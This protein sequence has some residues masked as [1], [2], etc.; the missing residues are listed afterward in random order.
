VVAVKRNYLLFCGAALL[1]LLIGEG[2]TIVPPDATDV[3]I[4]PLSPA[5][6][7][8][9]Y[10]LPANQTQSDLQRYLADH[11]WMRDTSAERSL[12]RDATESP[13]RMVFTGQIWFGLVPQVATVEVSPED[14]RIVQVRVF[15]CFTIAPWTECL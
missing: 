12:R 9:T 6:L 10:H 11:G 7:Q 3:R 1:G 14:R 13:D 15:R 2:H 8:I 4:D 5:R